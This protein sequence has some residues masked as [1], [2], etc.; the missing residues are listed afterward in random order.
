MVFVLIAAS[1][2]QPSIAGDVCTFERPDTW[3]ESSTQWIGGFK[4]GKADGLGIMKDTRDGKVVRW[5]FGRML[6]GKWIV[7]SV[8]KGR[9]FAFC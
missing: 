4:G 3:S 8:S 9:E 5:F 1:F 2:S 7:R 6:A